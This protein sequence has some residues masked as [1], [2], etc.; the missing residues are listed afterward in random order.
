[1]IQTV[2]AELSQIWSWMIGVV[3]GLGLFGALGI[4]GFVVL[5]IKLNR[6]QRSID[7]VK[8]N[9]VSETRDLSIRLRKL[10]K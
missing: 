4:V 2:I 3:A 8:N 10:E 7:N 6:L 9:T 1:M 5:Y